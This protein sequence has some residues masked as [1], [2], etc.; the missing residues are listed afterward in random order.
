M[1]GWLV[2]MPPLGMAAKVA[3]WAPIEE[4]LEA[5]LLSGSHG[6]IMWHDDERGPQA[7]PDPDVP[8]GYVFVKAATGDP[9]GHKPPWQK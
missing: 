2:P 5:A 6:V 8:Y 9:K 4:A 7:M 1:K 3:S